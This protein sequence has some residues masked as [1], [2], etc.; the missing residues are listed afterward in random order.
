MRDIFNASNQTMH[1]N[2]LC[3]INGSIANTCI[4]NKSITST[5]YLALFLYTISNRSISDNIYEI[6]Y[7]YKFL[8]LIAIFLNFQVAL[9][10]N[11]LKLNNNFH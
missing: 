3:I 9:V 8:P 7:N 11:L 6:S 10:M 4:T 2:N 1:K 5:L